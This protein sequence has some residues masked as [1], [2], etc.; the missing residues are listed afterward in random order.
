MT[1]RRNQFSA[2]YSKSESDISDY[3]SA[4]EKLLN[5]TEDHPHPEALIPKKNELDPLAFSTIIKGVEPL[6][7]QPENQ[8]NPFQ[9]LLSE[10]LNRNSE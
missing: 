1:T 8:P 10:I 9:R 6:E 4:E 3:C 5:R 7:P 2:L